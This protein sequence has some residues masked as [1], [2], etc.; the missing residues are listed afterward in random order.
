MGKLKLDGNILTVMNLTAGQAVE[1]VKQRIR[2][3]VDF[4]QVTV[5]Q[6]GPGVFQVSYPLNKGERG[7]YKHLYDKQEKER[8]ANNPPPEPP[9]L[10][11]A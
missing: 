5:V 10:L 6:S 7:S 11:L 2:M 9:P 4:T 8:K 3:D 1:K